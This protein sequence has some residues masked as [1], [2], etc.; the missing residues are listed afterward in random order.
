MLHYDSMHRTAPV[1]SGSTTTYMAV[2]ESRF[3]ECG[4]KTEDNTF[5][6]VSERQE[7][8]RLHITMCHGL[9][10]QQMSKPDQGGPSR[11]EDQ[12]QC[13]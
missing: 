11:T 8:M 3:A 2:W 12:N 13:T 4:Y 7:E 9:K 1:A 6:T 10:G 5:T